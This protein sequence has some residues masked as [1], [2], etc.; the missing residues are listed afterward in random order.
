MSEL[1]G[2][3]FCISILKFSSRNF[4]VIHYISMH[5]AWFRSTFLRA[6]KFVQIKDEQCNYLG[7]ATLQNVWI[8]WFPLLYSNFKSFPDPKSSSFIRFQCILNDSGVFF[9][10]SWNFNKLRGGGPNDFVPPALFQFENFTDPNFSSF[11]RFQCFFHD[12]GVLF[13]EFW[14]FYRLK[15]RDLISGWNQFCR[16]SELFGSPFC[17]SILKVF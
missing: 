9:W 14:K 15:R 12:A 16:V 11:V 8:I 6:F 2:P 5:C 13:K 17:I 7:E 3:S 4:F 1:F 10:E